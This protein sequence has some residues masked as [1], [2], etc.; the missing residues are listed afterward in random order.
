MCIRDRYTNGEDV[1]IN[2]GTGT[3]P[4]LSIGASATTMTGAT[5]KTAGALTA[6]DSGVTNITCTGA[7]SGANNG[8]ISVK[9]GVSAVAV[10]TA[11]TNYSGA[12]QITFAG[13]GLNQDRHVCTMAG[14]AA[15]ITSSA[16]I[17]AAAGTI[18]VSA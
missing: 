10:S 15:A 9:L 5:I 16:A 6:L 7:Q 11:G 18:T 4:V 14:R 3:E 13:T 12:P 8:R 17:G 2:I 1:N